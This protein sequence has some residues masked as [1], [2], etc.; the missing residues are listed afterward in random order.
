MLNHPSLD[1]VR[2]MLA[3]QGYITEPSIVM[4]V[5]L[6]MELKKPLLIEGP[7]GVGKNRDR[8]SHGERPGHRT[9]SLTVLRRIGCHSC[10]LRMELPTATPSTQTGRAHG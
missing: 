9:H 10:P 7:A 6:A 4:S 1:K 5:F 2:D 3:Q 8:Q